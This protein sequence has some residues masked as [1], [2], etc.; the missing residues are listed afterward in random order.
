MNI[1]K[2]QVLPR[3]TEGE[4]EKAAVRLSF[5]AEQAASGAA[6][7]LALLL[8]EMKEVGVLPRLTVTVF[9]S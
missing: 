7:D 3:V 8:N 1:V 9:S 4:G 2:A 5:Q 6:E